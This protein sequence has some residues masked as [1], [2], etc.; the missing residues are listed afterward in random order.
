[1]HEWLKK[2]SFSNLLV[3]LVFSILLLWGA[4]GHIS[5]FCYKTKYRN[6]ESELGQLRT[7]LDAS[8]RE[9]Q[10]VRA[11]LDRI[12]GINNEAIEYIGRERDLLLTT[13]TTIK[14]I[15]AAVQDMA[16]YIDRLE[17]YIVGM[18]RTNINREEQIE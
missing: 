8:N 5:A 17:L 16:Q 7:E 11:E 12:E 14:E 3:L 2:N 1:M 6:V 10:A 15:R 4:T 9:Q 13:G 18:H